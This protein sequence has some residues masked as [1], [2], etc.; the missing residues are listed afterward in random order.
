MTDITQEQLEEQ[1]YTQGIERVRSAMSRNEEHGA[2]DNNPYAK[3]VFR[4][5]IEPVAAEIARDLEEGR[6]KAGR[7]AAHAALLNNLDLEGVA[8]IALRTSLAFCLAKKEDKDRNH[9]NLANTLGA[10]VHAEMVLT[11]FEDLEPDLY[12]TIARDLGRRKSKSLRHRMAVFRNQM[13]AHEVDCIEWPVGARDQVGMYLISVLERCG[14]L[15][16]GEDIFTNNKHLPRLIDLNVD[17]LHK[18]EEIKGFVSI[19]SPKYGPC[20][21]PPI[22]WT[23][24]SGGGYHTKALRRRQA[25]CFVK[26]HASS[27]E[28]YRDWH[29]PIVFKAANNLQRTSWRVNGRILDTMTALAEEGNIGEIVSLKETPRPEPLPWLTPDM[30]KENMNEVQLA[31]FIQWKKR[32]AEWHTETKLLRTKFI[33]FYAARTAAAE[34]RRHPAIYFVYFADS[35]GRFYPLTYGINPQGSDMQKALLEFAVAKPL[36]SDEAVAFFH[37]LGAN[38]YG[39][40]KATLA[41]RVAWVGE[42]RDMIL[43]MADDPLNNRDWLNADCPWQFLAWCFEYRDWYN[44]PGSFVSRL[45]VG[46]DGSCNGLQHL[47]AM[48]RDPIGGAATNL[49]PAAT[50]NDIYKQVAKAAERRLAGLSYVGEG[51]GEDGARKER[52]RLIWLGKGVERSAVKRA[53]MTTPYGVT[54]SSATD[55]VIKDYLAS[56][57]VPEFDRADWRV[58]AQVLMDAVWPAIG[59]VVVRGSLVMKWLKKS[60]RQALKFVNDDDK[61]LYWITPSGFLAS[62]AHFEEKDKRVRTHLYGDERIRVAYEGEDPDPYGHAAGLPP[63]FIHSLDAAH[64][65]LCSAKASDLGITHLAMIHDDYGTHA[66]DAAKLYHLIREEFVAMYRDHDPLAELQEK[67]HLDKPPSKGDLD[68]EA[69]KDSEF[70]FS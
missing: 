24:S 49:V 37:V 38:K 59:D 25:A 18:I 17:L 52:L 4:N 40:D 28:L 50:M 23:S 54:R 10:A 9:R 66:A 21:E 41:E 5:W 64:L 61:T 62:Q 48:T 30:K 35:R 34:Y 12:H 47:S 69:V 32:V 7:K 65:H 56:G 14:V 45:A 20:I 15:E 3:F 70:F 43:A 27:R 33:R 55:Y 67:Y 8:L 60:A 42:R 68:I 39:Y 44:D 26:C 16:V 57:A 51:A 29:A 22:D 46:F 6:Q 53:V 13:T 11:Q 1:M 31:S 19:T 36:D 63:N 58:A 2:A